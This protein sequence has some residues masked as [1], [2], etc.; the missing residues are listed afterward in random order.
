MSVRLNLSRAFDQR[1]MRRI[2][3]VMGIVLLL[4]SPV[5][6]AIPG[7]GGL[8][9][10]GAGLALVLRSSSSAKRHYVRFK[11]SRP[12]A[13]RWTDRALQRRSAKL[14]ERRR[15]VQRAGLRN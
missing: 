5:I 10:A 7:P 2:F 3:F 1:S 11:R 12:K 8:L 15:K 4:L 6:G 13:G 14:R 9:V